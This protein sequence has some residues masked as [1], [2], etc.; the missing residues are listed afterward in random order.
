MPHQAESAP[1]PSTKK[2]ALA[3]SALAS[4]H[5]PLLGSGFPGRGA[6]LQPGCTRFW[7]Q[8]QYVILDR[9]RRHGRSDEGCR[10][11]CSGGGRPPRIR[12]PS[13]RRDRKSVV[14]GKSVDLGGLR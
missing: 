7:Y 3:A 6:I 14:K 10:L 13:R 2:F 12:T 5:P 11:E 1:R 9:A 8:D 4:A